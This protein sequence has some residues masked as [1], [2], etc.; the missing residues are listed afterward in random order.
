MTGMDV[1]SGLV[2][3]NAELLQTLRGLRGGTSQPSG[4]ANLLCA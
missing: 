3:F 4:D 1:T 2:H